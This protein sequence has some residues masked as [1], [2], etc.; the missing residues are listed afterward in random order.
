VY[1]Q[2]AVL[3]ATNISL[4]EWLGWLMA[5]IYMGGRVPQIWL[6]IKRGNVE[7]LNPLMFILALIANATYTGSILERSTEWEK[8][9]ANMP[10]LLDAVVCVVLDLFIILQYVYYRYIKIKKIQSIESYYGNGG[11]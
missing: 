3:V 6:N 8:I 11:I 4:G 5:A 7:G 2:D 10:W 9:K 1:R